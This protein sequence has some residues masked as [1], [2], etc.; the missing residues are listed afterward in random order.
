MKGKGV[1]SWGVAYSY[2]TSLSPAFPPSGG[3]VGGL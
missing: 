1:E 3:G 2:K